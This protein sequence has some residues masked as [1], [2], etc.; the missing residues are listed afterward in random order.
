[1]DFYQICSEK[2]N[3]L[4]ESEKNILDYVLR[5]VKET[6]GY[7]IRELAGKCYVSTASIFRL[8][9]KLGF[10]GY[11]DFIDAV[12]SADKDTERVYKSKP[13]KTMNGYL[14]NIVE[15]LKVISEAKMEQ[16]KQ[17]MIR[18][19]KIYILASGLS[20]DVANYIYRILT[21]YGYQVEMPKEDYEVSFAARRAKK[22]DVVLV[23]SYSGDNEKDLEQL[24]RIF[25]NATPTI[26]SFTR[27]DNNEIQNMS[28]L[29]FYTFADELVVDGQD[30]TSRCAM[31]A[32]F[33]VLMYQTIANKE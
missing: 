32:V 23:F 4:S 25:A 31:L 16:F 24:N 22:D 13:E 14:L 19:P 8:V 29:N 2:R 30:I 17:I 9:K 1:M 28:D 7:S 10:E 15:S 11:T 27:A 18:Y 20:Q 33:E 12:R 26:I 3:Q 21:I 6:A 5:H